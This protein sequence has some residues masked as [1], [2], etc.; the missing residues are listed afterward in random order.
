M[1]ISP[2]LAKSIYKRMM[3]ATLAS[4]LNETDSGE[5]Q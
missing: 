2:Y 1:F 5:F 3:V 4:S